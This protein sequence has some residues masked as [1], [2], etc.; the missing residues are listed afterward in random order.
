MPQRT[1]LCL[2]G[3]HIAPAMPRPSIKLYTYHPVAGV[4]ARIVSCV[5][6]RVYGNTATLRRMHV[7]SMDGGSDF[8]K[9]E[10]GD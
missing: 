1:T 3:K 2:A 8:E 10:D 6:G 7:E 4:Q 9:G 5:H